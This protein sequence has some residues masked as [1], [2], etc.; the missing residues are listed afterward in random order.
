VRILFVFLICSTFALA[1]TDWQRWEKKEPN[2]SLDETSLNDTSKHSKTIVD[3]TQSFY[4]YFISDLDGDN[5]A[6]HPSCS[7]FF[8][9]GVKQ[10]NLLKGTLMFAYRFTRDLNLFKSLSGY[11]YYY[12]GKFYDPA[13]NYLLDYNKI[14]FRKSN[15]N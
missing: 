9:E 3:Y 5:C 10:S 13:E 1:Q 12:T 11:S 4:Q 2:Y 14:T 6:F 7:H 15:S 8:V